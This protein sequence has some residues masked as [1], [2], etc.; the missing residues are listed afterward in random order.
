[1]LF[2]SNETMI[3]EKKNVQHIKEAVS[4]LIEIK[5]KEKVGT[6]RTSINMRESDSLT[7]PIRVT[8]IDSPLGSS[9]LV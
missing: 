3:R 6:Q 8:N 5:L 1:M 7:V 2:R 9:T 4:L